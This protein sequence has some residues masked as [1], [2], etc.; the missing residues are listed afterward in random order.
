MINK[1][2]LIGRAGKDPDLHTTQ[3]GKSVTRFSLAT[4][5]NYKDETSE[6]GWRQV[7]EWHN[8]VVWNKSA[9]TVSKTV[10]KGGLVYV[11]GA[12]HTRSYEDKE[13]NT[14]YITEVVGFAKSLTPREKKEDKPKSEP[15]ATKPAPDDSMPPEDFDDL[16]F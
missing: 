9:E 2:I 7:T 6:T 4:W 13:G 1:V 11:E 3:T 14:K 16:P 5:E 15:R 10:S 12:I 8:V